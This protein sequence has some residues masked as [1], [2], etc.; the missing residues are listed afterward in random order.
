MTKKFIDIDSLSRYDSKIKEYIDSSG[1][2]GGGGVSTFSLNSYITFD[3]SSLFP[4]NKGYMTAK[5]TSLTITS[6][7]FSTVLSKINSGNIPIVQLGDYYATLSVSSKSASNIRL[8]GNML[9]Y[10]INR[11]INIELRSNGYGSI[12]IYA[13]HINYY[14]HFINDYMPSGQSALDYGEGSRMLYDEV[15]V[16][17]ATGTIYNNRD[18]SEADLLSFYSA[19]DSRMYTFTNRTYNSSTGQITLRAYDIVNSNSYFDV[20]IITATITEDE[21]REDT[22]YMYDITISK[23]TKRVN[24]YASVSEVESLFG[25]PLDSGYAYLVYNGTYTPNA[26]IWNN[27]VQ[28]SAYVEWP[29]EA[30]TNTGITYNGYKV[31][32][33]AYPQ[34]APAGYYDKVIFNNLRDISSLPY[35]Q[36]ADMAFRLGKAY[37]VY[38]SQWIDIISYPTIDT[39]KDINMLSLQT[40]HNKIKTT[41]NNVT[42][43]ID[44]LKV[45]S[46]PAT[47]SSSRF[48]MLNVKPGVYISEKIKTGMAETIYLKLYNNNLSVVSDGIINVIKTPSDGEVGPAKESDDVAYTLYISGSAIYK[49]TIQRYYQSPGGADNYRTTTSQIGTIGSNAV[50]RYYN[51]K[52]YNSSSSRFN[53]SSL[54]AG[55][56]QLYG[57]PGASLYLTGTYKYNS[58]S[59]TNTG[60]ITLPTSNDGIYYLEVLK[61]SSDA[62]KSTEIVAYLHGFYINNA[63]VTKTKLLI[64]F[65]QGGTFSSGS[66]N[67]IL[68]AVDL[69]TTQTISGTKTFSTLPKSSITPTHSYHLTNKS[70]VDT[71][72]SNATSG[73]TGDPIAATSSDIN[74]LF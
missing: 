38:T 69:T 10:D 40:Y 41:L 23:I 48:D 28:S 60:S 13:E 30:M 53:I 17:A 33:Y 34:S 67:T 56:Y 63:Y 37:N 72:I 19:K 73:L 5:E 8:N 45:F 29:G 25:V 1:S 11:P 55:V 36:T 24:N 21:T 9:Y 3:S 52:S 70:Y 42:S 20:I 27:S 44:D 71:A 57:T 7:H 61:T 18:T 26:Y 35:G 2:G 39:S 68:S 49:T 66:S 74:A 58:T 12:A 22:G 32:K 50:N 64:Y 51:V 31:W 47:T 43:T 6:D 54:T 46:I 4:D 65:N 15:K 62:V 59:T 16:L 14:G